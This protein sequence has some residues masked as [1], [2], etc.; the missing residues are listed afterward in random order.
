VIRR[1]V[2]RTGGICTCRGF[3]VTI[4]LC[5]GVTL[6]GLI[7]GATGRTGA[8]LTG[9]TLTGG[10]DVTGI[11]TVASAG[12]DDCIRV[13]LDG[14]WTSVP[15]AGTSCAN[16]TPLAVNRSNNT[17]LGFFTRPPLLPA[18]DTKWIAIRN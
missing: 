8:I 2:I 16:A 7:L 9:A 15:G 17:S 14:S 18:D 3:A 11:T 6:T 13:R 1:G 4:G 10:I 5:L 12:L